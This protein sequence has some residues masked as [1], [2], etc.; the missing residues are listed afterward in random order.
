MHHE[1]QKNKITQTVNVVEAKNAFV[2]Q[3]ELQLHP[4][5]HDIYVNVASSLHFAF[6]TSIFMTTDHSLS[7]KQSDALLDWLQL[8]VTTLPSN[9]DHNELKQ[10]LHLIES[11]LSNIDHVT[12]NEENFLNVLSK[13]GKLNQDEQWTKSCS[14]GVA[15][16]G[17]TCGLWQLLHSTSIGLVHYNK[18]HSSMDK[19][20]KWST[21]TAAFVIRNYIE[22]YFTCEECRLNFIKMY[23]ECRFDRCNRLTTDIGTI[24]DWKQLSLWLWEVHND[25]NIRLFREGRMLNGDMGDITENE[26]ERVRWPSKSDCPSCWYD[27]GGWDEEAVYNYLD[28]FYW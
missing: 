19:A 9:I 22:E 18:N 21:M 28:S 5:Q 25:V 23:E 15:G 3:N 4:S 17:Y 13:N 16:A 11:L 24:D 2:Q 6:R 27:G 14:K 1:K 26:K 12:E 10:S 20:P 7:Q 8:L